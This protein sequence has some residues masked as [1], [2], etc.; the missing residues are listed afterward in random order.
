[1][2]G[3]SPPSASP[4]PTALPAREAVRLLEAREVSPLEL[5]DAALGHV[6]EVDPLVNAVPTQLNADLA[7]LRDRGVIAG[8]LELIGVFERRVA[9][10]RVVGSR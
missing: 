3:P 8:M 5:V 2:P 1:M 4:A 6:A 7:R 9:D 10:W